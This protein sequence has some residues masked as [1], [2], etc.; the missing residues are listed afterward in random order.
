MS[1]KWFIPSLMAAKGG[2]CGTNN[3][4]L[5]TGATYV[6]S[7]PPALSSYIY[8]TIFSGDGS[9]VSFTSDIVIGTSESLSLWFKINSG[10][11]VMFSTN[12]GNSAPYILFLTATQIAISTVTGSSATFVIPTVSNGTWYNLVIV[13]DA[14]T[15]HLYINGTESTTG[16]LSHTGNL[17]LNQ[18][19][20][21]FDDSPP[22]QT[23]RLNG[24]IVDIRKFNAVLTAT[25]ISNLAAGLAPVT[26]SSFHLKLNEGSGT[27]AY[28]WC[29]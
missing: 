16:G 13:R 7:V 1:F 11:N 9:K 17:S 28:D 24:N 15:T 21:F 14:G 27:T 2:P 6:S 19:G 5:L 18:L 26:P 3:G 25:D 4:T 20:V 29:N 22:Y 12:S 10:S 8:S 23:Y